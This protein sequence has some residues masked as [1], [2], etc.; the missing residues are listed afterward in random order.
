MRMLFECR[1]GTSNMSNGTKGCA[2]AIRTSLSFRL[3]SQ[4][5]FDVLGII[6]SDFCVRWWSTSST[7]EL[8]ILI[9]VI[10]DNTYLRWL[11]LNKGLFVCRQGFPYTSFDSAECLKIWIIVFAGII[12]G[13]LTDNGAGCWGSECK[14]L[15]QTSENMK[16]LWM[17]S[18]SSCGFGH[19]S[20][21]IASIFGNDT[22]RTMTVQ[23]MLW[24][25]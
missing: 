18:T 5:S 25:L 3:N 7:R 9:W 14:W 23:K 15:L 6:Q 10:S 19:R 17:S 2:E 13:T 20:I 24:T 11:S 16:V 8:N 12:V 21:C 1:R 22:S 4:T